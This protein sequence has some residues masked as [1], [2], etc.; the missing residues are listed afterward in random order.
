LVIVGNGE[1]RGTLYFGDELLTTNSVAPL[2]SHHDRIPRVDE[3]EVIDRR[4]SDRDL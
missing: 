4:D 2:P 3:V 1:N